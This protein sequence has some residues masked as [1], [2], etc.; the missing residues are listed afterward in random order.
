MARLC[1]TVVASGEGAIHQTQPTAWSDPQS[2]TSTPPALKLYD[3]E[4]MP[5]TLK[6]YN[7]L[8]NMKPDDAEG[9]ASETDR[10]SAGSDVS[11]HGTESLSY[12]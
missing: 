8:N 12:C 2:T 6:L 11:T 3:E 9:G 1:D 4:D 10:A 5:K 7:E